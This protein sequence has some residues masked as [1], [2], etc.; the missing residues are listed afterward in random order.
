MSPVDGI[1]PIV[2]QRQ[3]AEFAAVPS[4]IVQSGADVQMQCIELSLHAV[5]EAK[6]VLKT[7]PPLLLM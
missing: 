7:R 6:F 1:H 2:P 5:V 4:V 3:G